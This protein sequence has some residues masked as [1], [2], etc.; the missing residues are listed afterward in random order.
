MQS[1]QKPPLS[2]PPCMLGKCMWS[3]FDCV[4]PG[5]PTHPLEQVLVWPCIL[6]PRVGSPA[7]ATG[8]PHMSCIGSRDRDYGNPS[9]KFILRSIISPDSTQWACEPAREGLVIMHND[10]TASIKM[11]GGD[12]DDLL[13]STLCYRE[14]ATE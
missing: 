3:R 2:E 1:V 14:L 4:V 11:Q 6:G 8:L 9:T 12:D 5:L 10:L 7:P 13:A